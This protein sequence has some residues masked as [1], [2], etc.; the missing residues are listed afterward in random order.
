MSEWKNLKED[1]E[2][3][4]AGFNMPLKETALNP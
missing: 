2:V 4:Q 3:I 1:E